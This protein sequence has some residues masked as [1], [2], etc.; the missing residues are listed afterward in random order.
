MDQWQALSNGEDDKASAAAS[1]ALGAP[2]ALGFSPHPAFHSHQNT[3]HGRVYAAAYDAAKR[4]GVAPHAR[5][6][7][8]AQSHSLLG[9]DASDHM[10][11]GDLGEHIRHEH[12]RH[13]SLVALVAAARASHHASSAESTATSPSGLGAAL[14]AAPTDV[15]AHIAA[16]LGATP[17]QHHDE[18]FAACDPKSAVSDASTTHRRDTE[19]AH[20]DVC[21]ASSA[22]AAVAC[23]TKP[24]SIDC[25]YALSTLRSHSCSGRA[26]EVADH[27]HIATCSSQ[28]RLAAAFP[29]CTARCVVAMHHIGNTCG[30]LVPRAGHRIHPDQH[31]HP[32]EQEQCD[33]AVRD[34]QTHCAVVGSSHKTENVACMDALSAVPGT[35]VAKA[36]EH[37]AQYMSGKH[38]L[39]WAEA[40]AR[41]V[42]HE[43]LCGL[44]SDGHLDLRGNSLMGSVPSC[45]ISASSESTGN[46]FISR[47]D[48]SGDIGKLGAHV[49]TV[50]ANDNRL[51]GDLGKARAVSMC[52]N[53]IFTT[54]SHI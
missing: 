33:R 8:L 24:G 51:S 6:L 7:A 13:A 11:G 1:S 29:T 22:A 27:P 34:A 10:A 48:F 5:G 18:W 52:E 21:D 47:N 17:V 54:Y 50:V 41:G 49:T 43:G 9:R 30:F 31:D 44:A 20:H 15:S 45:M 12:E 16:I 39:H 4:A 19:E 38:V 23:A 53:G 46:L 26:T 42:V 14:R 37:S 25:A 35:L 36:A 28:E 32:V 40:G 3:V 2:S